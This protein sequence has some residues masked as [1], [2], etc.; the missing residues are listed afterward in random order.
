MKMGSVAKPCAQAQKWLDNPS[1]PNK[2]EAPQQALS[3]AHPSGSV[4]ARKPQP[5]YILYVEIC[6]GI[7]G[8]G[9]N[10]KSGKNVNV[11]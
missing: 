3:S 10:A 8:S 6:I 2:M 4:T 1:S 9:R 5:G 7:E 11:C